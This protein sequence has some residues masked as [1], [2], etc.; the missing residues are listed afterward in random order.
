[1]TKRVI[2][3]VFAG[4][5]LSTVLGTVSL[6][7]ADAQTKAKAK[8]QDTK[9]A[10]KTAVFEMYKDKAGEYRFRLKDDEGKLLAISGKG[11]DDKADCQKVI[12]TIQRDAARAKV[13]DQSNK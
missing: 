1:M 4:L 7:T 10:T 6:H 3:S 9:G 13:D 5:M 12:Q 8:P 11:Y 2:G